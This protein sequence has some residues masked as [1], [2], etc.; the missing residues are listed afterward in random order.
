MC[1][2]MMLNTQKSVAVDVLATQP[3]A[4]SLADNDIPTTCDS[5]F[6][7]DVLPQPSACA[8]SDFSPSLHAE[9]WP[10][11]SVLMHTD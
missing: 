10:V 11:P 9:R 5:I 7:I 8:P 2:S 4:S 1:A 3:I 6:A